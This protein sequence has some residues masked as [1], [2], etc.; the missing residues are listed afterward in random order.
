MVLNLGVPLDILL[1]SKEECE[2]NFRNHN[3]LYLN[4][5]IDGRI[6]YDANFLERLIE[7]TKEYIKTNNIRRGDGSWSFPVK[8]R[9]VTYI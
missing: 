1:V 3:P 8:D 7:E 6:I 5:A 4:I 9:V 2:Y